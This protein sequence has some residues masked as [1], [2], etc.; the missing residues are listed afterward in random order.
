[1]KLSWATT[2]TTMPGC[3]FKKAL[4]SGGRKVRTAT[5]FTLRRSVPKGPLP[6][7]AALSTAAA[8]SPSA[9]TSRSGR[10]APASVGVTLRVVRLRRRRPSRASSRRTAALRVEA[11][12][13]R[14]AAAFR[15]LRWRATAAK[16]ARSARSGR[17]SA[18][19]I[20]RNFVQPVLS[21]ADYRTERQ[22][23]SW[24]A[25][26]RPFPAPQMEK[27]EMEM[28]K[29]GKSGPAVSAL[30]LGAM[31][32]SGMYGP[33]DRRESI[34]TVRAALDAGITLIDTGDF[35]GMGHNEMLLGEAL[36]G[37]P[38]DRFLVS[39]KFGAMRDPRGGW[40]GYDARPAAVK[41]F[42]AYS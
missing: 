30:G 15:K 18:S 12:P 3:A 26:G 38:R 28:R 25:S 36:R 20:V 4:T 5:Q 41:N 8:T 2:S 29:L 23:P 34:A 1:M 39:V 14:R 21:M 35:Y 6:E 22:S 42:L 27:D 13:P 32:M 40:V 19:A 11:E 33:A 37:V 10:R 7:A 24:R 16:A 17:R 9:G 31:G